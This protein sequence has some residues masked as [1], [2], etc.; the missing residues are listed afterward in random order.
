MKG[1]NSQ[2]RDVPLYASRVKAHDTKKPTLGT[3]HGDVK[4]ARIFTGLPFIGTRIEVGVTPIYGIK[5]Q[6]I[7]KLQPLSLV[8][9]GYIDAF[10]DKIATAKVGL[11]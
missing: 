11:F 5:Y 8:N 2:G 3:C 6:H 1:V 10:G 4:L 7:I 9:G